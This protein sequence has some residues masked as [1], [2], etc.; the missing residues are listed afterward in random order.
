ML[1]MNL[2]IDVLNPMLPKGGKKIAYI[3]AIHFHY[4]IA[5]RSPP[6]NIKNGMNPWN[7][8]TCQMQYLRDCTCISREGKMQYGHSAAIEAGERRD[9]MFIPR[10]LGMC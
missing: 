1:R 10:L 2:Y 9:M 5:E 8:S 4:R 7:Y 6:Y 3:V